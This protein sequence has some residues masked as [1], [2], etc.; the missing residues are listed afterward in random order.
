LQKT[1]RNEPCP[2]G[3]GKKYKKCCLEKDQAAAS[4]VRDAAQTAPAALDWLAAQFPDQVREAVEERYYGGLKKQERALL[5]GLGTRE[6]EFLSVNVGEWLL[7]DAVLRIGDDLTPVRRLFQNPAGPPLAAGGRQWLE[8]LADHALKLYEVRRVEE[9]VGMLLSDMLDPAGDHLWVSDRVAS[10]SF[11]RWQVIG[12][13]VLAQGDQN[14]L[15]GALYPLDRDVAAESVARIRR[16]TRGEEHGSDLFREKCASVII[17]DWLRSL[18]R[19]S[20]PPEQEDSGPE[21]ACSTENLNDAETWI[22]GPLAA[23]DGKSPGEAVK[24]AAGRRAVVEILKSAELSD[25]E[26]VRSQ[27][28]ESFPFHTLWERLGL[29]PQAC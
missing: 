11:L 19:D 5:D 18:L 26:R 4:R 12:A 13:R 7:T 27:G 2:C 15:S 8:R 3:S 29:D 6:Q 25:Q 1:G 17:T 16:R 21:T 24:T 28:G 14:V 22:N 9:G 23:L 20:S 10:R